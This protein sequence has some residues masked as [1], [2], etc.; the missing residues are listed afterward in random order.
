MFELVNRLNI[1]NIDSAIRKL[2]KLYKENP[3]YF[4]IPE[5]AQ[6]AY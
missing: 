4:D 3:S 5:F 2:R 1:R 6:K